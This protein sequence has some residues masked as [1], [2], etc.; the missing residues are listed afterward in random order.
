M[1][2]P[3]CVTG[4]GRSVKS[5]QW[6]TGLMEDEVGD[7]NNVVDGIEPDCPEPGL[8]PCR[9]RTNLNAAHCQAGVTYACVRGLYGDVYDAPVSVFTE[10]GNLRQLCPD[11]SPEIIEGSKIARH[12]EV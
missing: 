11:R 3:H 1:P 5:M 4:D 2:D 10:P 9:R 7:V 12:T 8:Q 6:L